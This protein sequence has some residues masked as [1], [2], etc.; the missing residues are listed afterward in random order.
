[1]KIAI[2]LNEPYPYG[3]ACTNRIHLY[4]KGLVELGNDVE[5]LVPRF[6]EDRGKAINHEIEGEFEGVKFKYACNPIRSKSFIGRRKQDYSSLFNSFMFF[7][8]FKPKIVLVVANNLKYIML[9]KIC[10]FFIKAKIVREKSEV[11]YYKVQKISG[12]RKIKTILE[13]KLFD[14]LIVISGEL[15]DFF[16]KDL[17]LKMNI[18]EVPILI[19]C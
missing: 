13:F 10:S 9:A 8:H 11:P 2:L 12:F 7:I 16:L 14:G 19:N 4:A 15:K 1:M 3:M 6:T 18:L 17:F 5:I